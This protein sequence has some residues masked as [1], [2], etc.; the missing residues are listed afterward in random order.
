MFISSYLCQV[1]STNANTHI[2]STIK[3]Q[4]PK[5][6]PAFTDRLALLALSARLLIAAT[7]YLPWRL[8]ASVPFVVRTVE[9]ASRRVYGGVGVVRCC[10]CSFALV[11]C[12]H[13]VR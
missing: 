6:T 5:P 11:I 7:L 1:R 4:Q 13:R 9:W 3:N 8:L 10:E 2:T 12:Y